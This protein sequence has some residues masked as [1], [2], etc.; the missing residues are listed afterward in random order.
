MNASSHSCFCTGPIS[1]AVSNV[2]PEWLQRLWLAELVNKAIYLTVNIWKGPNHL[3][4]QYNLTL[5][6][7]SW[8]PSLWK[9]AIRMDTHTWLCLHQIVSV[10]Q[11]CTWIHFC[12]LR[13][14]TRVHT[15]WSHYRVNVPRLKVHVLTILG[16]WQYVRK[17]LLYL[18][19]PD[20]VSAKSSPVT[21]DYK[22]KLQ[23]GLQCPCITLSLKDIFFLSSSSFDS[24]QVDD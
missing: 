17:I 9:E 20:W 10:R 13:F 7:E 22:L 11:I 18:Q 12:I 19:L 24:S 1:R 4:I 23:S 6:C 15:R 2:P 14:Y 16:Y 21:Q 8:L 5:A 3:I